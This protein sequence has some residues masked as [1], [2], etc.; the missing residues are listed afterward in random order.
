MNF[1]DVICDEQLDSGVGHITVAFN[2]N[3]TVEKG[4]FWGEGRGIYARLYLLLNR[5]WLGGSEP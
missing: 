5:A 1:K 3:M 4:H 2:D